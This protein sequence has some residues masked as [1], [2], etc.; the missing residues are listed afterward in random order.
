[1]KKQKV[2]TLSAGQVSS[3]SCADNKSSSRASIMFSSVFEINWKH[4]LFPVYQ[5]FTSRDQACGE[6]E[7]SLGKTRCI[8]KMKKENIGFIFEILLCAEHCVVHL[9]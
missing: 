5:S 7:V 6:V 2:L 1:M 4:L 9:T 3:L 8:K